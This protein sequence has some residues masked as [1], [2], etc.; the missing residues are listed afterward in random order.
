[1]RWMHLLLAMLLALALAGCGGDSKETAD[2][3]SPDLPPTDTAGEIAGEVTAPDVA[4]DVDD[5]PFAGAVPLLPGPGQ[6]GYDEELEKLARRYDR[7]FQLFNA[8]TTAVNQDMSIGL[9][10]EELR[11][12]M[13]S[14]LRESDGWDFEGETGLD[15]MAFTPGWAKV[16]GL[17]GGV[18]I[19]ADAYRYGVLRDQGYAVE[20]VERAREFVLRAM[21]SFHLATAITGVP[22]VIARGFIRTDVPGDGVHETTMP[23]FDEEG[24]PL[25]EPK[26]NGTWREDNSGGLYPNYIW[27]DSCSRDQYIGW[28]AAAGALWEVVRNDPDIPQEYKDRLQADA[29]ELGTALTVVRESGYDLELPDADGRTTLHGYMNEQCIDSNLYVPGLRNGFHAAMALGSAATWA[30]VSE[31]PE[32]ESYLYDELIDKRALHEMPLEDLGPVNTGVGTNFSNFNMAFQGMWLALRYID[33]SPLAAAKLRMALDTKL[34]DNGGDRQP[35]IQKQSLYDFVYAAGMA[36]ANVSTPMDRTLLDA[37]ALAN[38]LETLSH[39]PEPPYWDVQV[40][41]CDEAELESKE[42][43]AN[44]GMAIDVIGESGW[45]GTLVGEQVVP[46]E[47]RPPSN[48][49]WRSDPFAFNGGGNGGRLIPAVDFRYAYWLGRWTR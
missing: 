18:G 36:G 25:P 39:F 42:C 15:L 41:N 28:V 11:Q 31:D 9:E 37:Q 27:E 5:G 47:I 29:K 14:F 26:N 30:Y 10:Q 8:A 3:T 13:E 19:A 1:M 21:D 49:H 20:E 2:T 43:I 35:R 12:A 22:G 40:I 32:L 23:L 7:Q 6:E 16:A 45:K 17:Y 24:N 44:N 38:G 34:Y 4:A 33:K 48:Y 46:M